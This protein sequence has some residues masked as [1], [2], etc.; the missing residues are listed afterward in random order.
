[1]VIALLILILIAILAPDFAA[2][3]IKWAFCIGVIGLVGFIGLIL[4]I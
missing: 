1:M 4:F 2:T 3:L